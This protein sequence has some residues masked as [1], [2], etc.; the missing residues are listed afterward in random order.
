MINTEALYRLGCALR[1]AGY[2][3]TTITPLTHARVL[4]RAPAADDQERKPSTS[5][6][7]IF[8]WSK[9][10]ERAALPPQLFALLEESN[11][12]THV[13]EAPDKAASAPLRSLVRF[14]TLRPAGGSEAL[15]V[16]SA[17]PTAQADSVF[18]GPDTYRFAALIER[19][20]RAASKR[21][22]RILD[23]GCGAGPGGIT[24]VL[25]QGGERADTDLVLADINP[26]ALEYAD[27][28]AR[29]AGLD[30]CSLV[31]SDL[32][33]ALDGR[34]DLIVANPP[35]LVDGKARTYRNGGGELGIG[36]SLRIVEEGLARL[37][38]DGMLILYTGAPVVEGVDVL[39]Q[40][41][42]PVLASAG[43]EYRYQELDPDVFGEELD[44]PAYGSV[45]RIAAV[46][47]VI[48][49]TA[50]R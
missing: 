42:V 26:A 19:E 14:S 23:I 27:V 28:N 17:Y 44:E 50:G 43:I 10:F 12:L 30:K 5:L 34:F 35:Y 29:L 33:A 21:F 22:G 41:L 3:F 2:S 47:L 37:A 1:E 13:I 9:P 6:R 15:Y 49:A 48:R 32:Y 25:A 11:A 46:A 16:H 36:L 4:A 18:F 45:E 39:Q 8:G 40:A 24:A 20:V 7:D 38:E 31:Q